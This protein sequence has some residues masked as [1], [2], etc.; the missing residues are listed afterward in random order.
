MK[1]HY[2]KLCFIFL[3]FFATGIL[4]AQSN[5]Y[6][7]LL[8]LNYDSDFP[9]IYPNQQNELQAAVL[10]D[11]RELKEFQISHLP[12]A[13]WVGFSDFDVKRLDGLSKDQV[14]VVYCSIG[15]R[16]ETIGK[17]LK[18]LGFSKVFNLYGGIFH[19]VNEGYGVEANGKP[20][21]KIHAYNKMWGV[22][23]NKGEK[24]Y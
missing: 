22:W 6:K 14:V 3:L 11:T 18:E 10:L 20:T 15:V 2:L 1:Q 8:D 12:G 17:K 5:A 16:S 4:H 24:I 7:L 21:R 19:W 23:L 13:R 9:L